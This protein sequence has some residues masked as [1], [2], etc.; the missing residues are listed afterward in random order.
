MTEKRKIRVSELDAGFKHAVARVHGGE[1][2]KACFACGTC[3]ASCPIREI[4]DRYNPRKIIRMV[5]LGMKE[6]VLKSD[7]IWLCSTCYSC[8]E[9]CPQDVKITDLMTAL[10]NMAVAAGHLPPAFKLQGD[11]LKA[12]GRLY[13]IDEFDNKKREKMGLPMVKP[14]VDEVARVMELSGFNKKTA[15]KA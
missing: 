6:E 13:E 15:P 5:L 8:Y 9:R 3:T 10:K 12:N 11:L 7:F 2:V 14:K 1:R 4:D